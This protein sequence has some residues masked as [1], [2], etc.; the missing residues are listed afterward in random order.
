VACAAGEVAARVPEVAQGTRE[1]ITEANRLVHRGS[2]QT[3][4]VVGAASLGFAFGLLI[5]GAPR[6]LVL[7]ALFPAGLVGAT[8]V[9]RAEGPGPVG[10]ATSR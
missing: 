6:V 1:V 7:G 5:G 9:E 3:L 10:K 8:L 4:K 2:D